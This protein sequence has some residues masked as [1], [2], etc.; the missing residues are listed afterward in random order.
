MPPNLRGEYPA[1]FMISFAASLLHG[2]SRSTTGLGTSL[3]LGRF[4]RIIPYKAPA[5]GL[6]NLLA[7]VL[8][9]VFCHSAHAWRISECEQFSSTSCQPSISMT[10]STSGVSWFRQNWPRIAEALTPILT[11]CASCCCGDNAAKFVGF[12]GK[13][14]ILTSVDNFGLF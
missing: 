6:T 12:V 4:F 3:G 13:V 11:R 8:G 10:C 1:D 9:P 14:S 5:S 2:G 7:S